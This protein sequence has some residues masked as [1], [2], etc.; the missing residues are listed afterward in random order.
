MDH[1]FYTPNSEQSQVRGP[2]VLRWETT[3]NVSGVVHPQHQQHAAVT[4]PVVLQRAIDYCEARCLTPTTHWLGSLML[5]ASPASVRDA[6]YPFHTEASSAQN[7]GNHLSPPP[8]VLQIKALAAMGRSLHGG[9]EYARCYELLRVAV[10]FASNMSEHVPS[11]GGGVPSMPRGQ[12]TGRSLSSIR[13]CEWGSDDVPCATS[14]DG[15][16]SVIAGGATTLGSA[17]SFSVPPAVRRV[18]AGDDSLFLSAGGAAGGRTG[19]TSI[20]AGDGSSPAPPPQSCGSAPAN[21]PAGGAPSHQQPSPAHIPLRSATLAFLALYALY[22]EGQQQKT[23]SPIASRAHG[24]A[25]L[26][27]LR[28]LLHSAVEVYPGDG[29]LL[30]LHGVVLRESQLKQEAAIQLLNAVRVAPFMWCAWQDLGTLVTRES[31]LADISASLRGLARPDHQLMFR[32]FGATVREDLG[33]H[34]AATSEWE[35]LLVSFPSSSFIKCHIGNCMYHRKDFE[36]ARSHFEDVRQTD[37]YRIE[38]TDDYSNV[39]FVRGDRVALSVLAQQVYALDPYRAE[40]NCVVGNYFSIVGRHDKSLF[41]FRRAVSIDPKYLSGWT[42]MGHEYLELKNTSAAVEAYRAAVEIDQRDYRAWYGLGQIYELLSMHHHSLYYYWQTTL[43]RPNDPRMWGA[44][45]NCLEHDR[46]PHEANACLE[47]AELYE[48]TLSEHYPVIVRRIATYHLNANNMSRAVTYLEKLVACEN[49]KPSD[50]L[51]ALPVLVDAYLAE[52]YDVFDIPTR[53]PSFDPS[54]HDVRFPQGNNE[55]G[56]GR[57][58]PS[59]DARRRECGQ[60]LDCCEQYLNLLIQALSLVGGAGEG[61]ADGTHAEDASAEGAARP[62]TAGKDHAAQT[63]LAGSRHHTT[64]QYI[65]QAQSNIL[66][67]RSYLASTSS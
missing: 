53:S 64:T 66:Y 48:P 61:N 62:H 34:S 10:P 38:G 22:L 51:F 13:P 4:L 52:I 59:T 63:R 41:H 11:C 29:S 2:S 30:W 19:G 20:F 33:Y 16:T 6:V 23:I 60:K 46:R 35:A 45:A 18:S 44:V 32:F 3:S 39:L 7:G 42:L 54:Q 28:G 14:V 31:Q 67:V 47:R 21:Q 27:P 37:P 17:P 43:L 25:N 58:R 65:L 9:K 55:T 56:K 26:R 15:E 36:K 5:S 50:L 1:Q 40:T 57:G 8:E 12:T 49:R 24:N